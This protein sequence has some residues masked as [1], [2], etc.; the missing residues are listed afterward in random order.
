V[1]FDEESESAGKLYSACMRRAEDSGPVRLGDG[2]PSALSPDGAWALTFVPTTPQKVVLLPTGPGQP[3]TLDTG[4]LTSIVVAASWMPD[5]RGVLVAGNRAGGAQGMWMLDAGGGPPHAVSGDSLG[6]TVRSA[7]RVAPDGR[8]VLCGSLDGKPVIY[9]LQSKRSTPIPNVPDLRFVGW[10]AD[11][12][13]LLATPRDPVRTQLVLVD[14]ETGARR[15]LF[16]IDHAPWETINTVRMSA[17]MKSYAYTT[18]SL[19]H[20]LY[21]MRGLR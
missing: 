13:S 4:P 6:F 2:I 1:L 12:R 8:R 18:S 14:P 7:H 3:R 10:T 20:D 5:G 15:K 11:G 9:D 19:L 16:D 21:L 17:D